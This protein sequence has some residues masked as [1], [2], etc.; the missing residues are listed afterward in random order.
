MYH[1]ILFEEEGYI[2]IIGYVNIKN[3]D[4]DITVKMKVGCY[5]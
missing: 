3:Y 4:K 5:S 2:F 1:M